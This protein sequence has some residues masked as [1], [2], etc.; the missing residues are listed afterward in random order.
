M[1]PLSGSQSL[2]IPAVVELHFSSFSAN[3]CHDAFSQSNQGRDFVKITGTSAQSPLVLFCPGLWSLSYFNFRR[4]I[5]VYYVLL[6]QV[7]LSWA[8]NLPRFQRKISKSTSDKRQ[9][10]AFSVYSA[11]LLDSEKFNIKNC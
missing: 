7:L 2:P 5:N 6:V 10:L 4:K 9:G 1:P 3:I 8:R 11:G